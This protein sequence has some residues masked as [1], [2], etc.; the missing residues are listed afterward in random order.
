MS[1]LIKKPTKWHVCPAK[2][3]ISL[4]GCPGL[5]ESSLGAHAISLVLSRGGSF[6]SLG[7]SSLFHIFAVFRVF[8]ANRVD[9]DQVLHSAVTDMVL[10]CLQSSFFGTARHK[11]VNPCKCQK[12]R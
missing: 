9:P 11:V 1:R 2:T 10:Q 4:G 7:V 8:T 12:N 3:Q 6:V 5:S